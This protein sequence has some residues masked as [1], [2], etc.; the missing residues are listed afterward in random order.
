M[1]LVLV[2]WRDAANYSGWQSVDSLDELI[3]EYLG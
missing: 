1:E 3:G 2:Q